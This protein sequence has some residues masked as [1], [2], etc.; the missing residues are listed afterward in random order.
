M[1]DIVLRPS[2]RKLAWIL[3]CG[4]SLVAVSL[5]L[6]QAGRGLFVAWFGL[7]FFGLCMC[8]GVVRLFD[9]RPRL[10]IG[11]AGLFDRNLGV[12]LISWPEIAG[13]TLRVVERQELLFL[14]MRDP[15]YWRARRPPL[16]RWLRWLNAG[17]GFGV[18]AFVIG[19]AD[20]EIK[21]SQVH[22]IVLERIELERQQQGQA[23]APAPLA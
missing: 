20:V 15:A 1:Q 2:R 4:A 13:A 3:L 9:R 23:A 16:R 19:F 7:V 12:G 5:W 22:A 17:F 14:E 6:I 18:D 10:M 21:G 11:E 8:A